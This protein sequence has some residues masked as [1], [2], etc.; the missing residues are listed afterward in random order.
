M[1]AFLFCAGRCRSRASSRALSCRP[2]GTVRP[3]MGSRWLPCSWR[4]SC[5]TETHPRAVRRRAAQ[6]IHRCGDRRGR[7][8]VGVEH[9]MPHGSRLACPQVAMNVRAAQAVNDCLGSP[10]ISKAAS[11]SLAAMRY[12]RSKTHACTG[13]ASRKS[14]DQ[15]DRVLGRMPIWRRS[16]ASAFASG[17]IFPNDI[18]SCCRAISAVRSPVYAGVIISVS[19]TRYRSAQIVSTSLEHATALGLRFIWT[20]LTG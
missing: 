6:L 5:D 20:T 14:L 17:S 10:I 13:T 4:S 9:A 8:M 2:G 19:R 15:C 16:A 18:V 12:R 11:R 3:G 7:A 1:P